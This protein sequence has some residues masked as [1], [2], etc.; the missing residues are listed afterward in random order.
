MKVR[1]PKRLRDG[2]TVDPKVAKDVRS[3]QDAAAL[4]SG[5][6]Y[7]IHVYHVFNDPDFDKAVKEARELFEAAY[8]K[9]I[10]L[11][12]NSDHLFEEHKLILLELAQRFCI[13]TREL[14]LYA[15]G[16]YDEGAS[17][18]YDMDELGGLIESGTYGL[19][20]KIGPKT[21]QKQIEADWKRIEMAKEDYYGV[22]SGKK[23]PTFNHLLVYAL[24]KA[25]S[26][27]P[28]Q[29]WQDIFEQYQSGQI[30]GYRI[31]NTKQYKTKED[32]ENFFNK[33]K[34]QVKGV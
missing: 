29:K 33:M 6:N 23:R 22:R 5:S 25:R 30:V 21:T 16:L 20:Y 34:P 17:Y 28:P 15:D 18:G 2:Q 7:R 9:D 3:I 12:P 27:D 31:K 24:F 1:I 4:R 11:D 8:Y 19:I 10:S 14:K 13:G 26:Q 32:L